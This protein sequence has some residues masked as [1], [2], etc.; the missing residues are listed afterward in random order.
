[1]PTRT[2]GLRWSL[3]L[4]LIA[5]ITFVMSLD[6]TAIAVAAPTIQ[7]EYDFSLFEMSVILTSFSWTYATVAGPR[8][9]VGRAL[10]SAPHAVLGQRAVV[11]A[12]RRD[13]AR[14]QP[15]LVRWPARVARRRPGGGLAEFHRGHSALVSAVRAGQGQFHFARRVVS[16][17]DRRRADHHL[18]HSGVRLALGFLR[19]RHARHRA[20]HRVVDR[21]SATGPRNTRASRPPKSRVDRRRAGAD[22]ADGSR[23]AHSGAACGRPSSGRSACSISSSC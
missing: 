19:L 9:L 12:D 13:A 5:P 14:V 10:R 7:H 6:R 8:R 15:D 11:R 16:R 4:F 21:S 22:G 23:P 3:M 2:G 20:R 18:G 1:M 17:P